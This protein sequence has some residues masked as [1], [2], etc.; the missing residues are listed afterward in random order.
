M[1][2]VEKNLLQK[3]L[4]LCSHNRTSIHLMPKK[5]LAESDIEEAAIE[6][7]LQLKSYRYLHGEDI[8]RNRKKAYLE[9]IFSDFLHETYKHVPAKILAEVQ[10][11]FL[12]NA[13]TDIH[14]RNH[15]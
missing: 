13:G 15:N 9:N 14:Q 3:N 7:L 5:Y 2:P 11:E 6:W 12:F 10:Q 8:S 1:I 4:N